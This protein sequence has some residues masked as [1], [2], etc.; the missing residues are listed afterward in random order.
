VP[1]NKSQP[2]TENTLKD[3]RP[4]ADKATT[5]SKL[6]A[7]P[8]AKM[9]APAIDKVTIKSRSIGILA[10]NGIDIKP[11]QP[12]AQ[13]MHE[14]AI[15]I[16][17]NNGNTPLIAAIL[18]GENDYALS[19]I[20]QGA[21]LNIKNKLDLSPLHIA[22]F[23]NNR[24]VTNHLLMKGADVDIKGNS[25]YTP[26]H[27]ASELN[28]AILAKDLLNKGAG[29]SIK[30]DQ[31]LSP[32]AIARIQNNNEVVKIITSKSAYTTALSESS[33]NQTGTSR[34]IVR[35]SPKYEF[36]LPYNEELLRK[37]QFNNIMT[38]VSIPVFSL[39]AAGTFYVR[40]KANNYYS[41]YK[42]AE[43]MEMAK[44]YYDKTMQF[45]A[46]TYISGGLSLTSAFGIVHSAIRRK[47]ISNKMR[48]RLY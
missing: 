33:S 20:D 6:P 1:A 27:I 34:N 44:H 4:G 24:T 30:T 22:V 13:P 48:K 39:A 5:K 43:T 16:K 23:L 46:Y 47:S 9:I 31:K 42:N 14:T 38:F 8:T 40:A 37:R 11:A 15:N 7:G 19:L 45:D 32:K 41:S 10:L 28:H 12:A 25:G 35:L 3:A 26:L 17:D 2:I 36:S 21:D 29:T 18:A